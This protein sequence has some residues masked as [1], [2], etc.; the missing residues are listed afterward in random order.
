MIVLTSLELYISIFN[1]AEENIKFEHYKFPDSKRGGI[2]Y[3]K[4]RGEIEK[5]LTKTDNTATHLQGY[6]SKKHRRL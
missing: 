6:R 1:K 5:N 2:S 3:E 4:V